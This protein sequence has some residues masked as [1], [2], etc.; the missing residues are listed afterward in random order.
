MNSQF[1]K[2][3]ILNSPYKYPD[4]HWE[5]DDDGQPT[6]TIVERRRRAEFISP[7]PKPKKRGGK[8]EQQRLVFDEGKGLSTR[9][10]QYAQHAE[11]INSVRREVDEWRRQPDP[12]RWRVTPE[13]QRLLQHWRHHRF[14][15]IRPFFCQVEAVETVIWLTEVAPQ[16]KSTGRRFLQYLDDA[17]QGSESRSAPPRAQ[18][19]HR[20]R[21]DHGDGHADCVADHQLGASSAEQSIHPRIPDRYTRPD[22]QGQAAGAEIER[23]GQL[24][25]RP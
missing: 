5:L 16:P 15:H 13:T 24:L 6:R 9:E 4:C 2:N 18:A 21:Q 17:S 14:G 8:T 7:I 1:F 3:P 19:G 12:N 23:P 25:P 11:I 10:Q 20:C 22:H